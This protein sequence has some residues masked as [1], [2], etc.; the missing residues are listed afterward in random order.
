MSDNTCGC[1]ACL[2]KQPP[3]E[4]LPGILV[5]LSRTYMVVCAICGNKRCPH[6]NDHRNPCTG[7]NAI[8]Q[9]GSSWEHVKPGAASIRRAGK[10]S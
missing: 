1:C 9:P 6:A 4:L 7:S 2:N 8:G 5:P 3:V 10:E